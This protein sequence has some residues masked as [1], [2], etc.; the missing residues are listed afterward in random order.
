MEFL[1]LL[2]AMA[3]V[4]ACCPQWGPGTHISLATRLVTERRD[5]IPRDKLA[6]LDRYPNDF[7]YGN[8][9]A[10]I[11]TMKKFGGIDNH[12]HNWN[13]HQR[14]VGICGPGIGWHVTGGDGS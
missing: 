9:A 14:A 10:D 1:L 3:L 11:I 7:L 8:I 6:L 5:E 2:S 4:Y 13:I 12:C